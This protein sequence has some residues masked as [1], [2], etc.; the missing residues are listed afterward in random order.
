[1]A[2]K[3]DL[4]SSTPKADSSPNPRS[5]LERLWASLPMRGGGE[6]VRPGAMAPP[7]VQPQLAAGVCQSMRRNWLGNGGAARKYSAG[8]VATIADCDRHVLATDGNT[9][10]RS[11]ASTTSGQ[12]GLE[13][14]GRTGELDG[15]SGPT[16]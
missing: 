11:A 12:A 4:A 2:K 16:A 6:T 15:S 3:P 1:M 13:V 10:S 9:G 5:W 14:C 8:F 7:P